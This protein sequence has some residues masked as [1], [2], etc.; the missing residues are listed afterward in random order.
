MICSAKTKNA[1]AIALLHR[2]TI[3]HG[4][5]AKLGIPFLQSL[6]KFLIR[7]ELVLTYCENN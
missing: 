4:F 3:N 6:Y 5:L 2:Q 7:K 1:Q